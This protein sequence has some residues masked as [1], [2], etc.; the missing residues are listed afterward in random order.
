MKLTSGCKR[1]DDEVGGLREGM[2][3]TVFGP[4][5]AGK[6]TIAIQYAL[7]ALASGYKVF[8][9]NTEDELFIDRLYEMSIRRGLN[10]NLERLHVVRATSFEEQHRILTR[11]LKT[12]GGGYGLI[13]VDSL[14]G[15]FRLEVGEST[16][17]RTLR[18]LNMQLATIYHQA[19]LKDLAAIVTSQV[20]TGESD[21]GYVASAQQAL[22]FW[23][24]LMLRLD[25]GAT[26]GSRII[27]VIKPE[28]KVKPWR[29]TLL[30]VRMSSEGLIC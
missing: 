9:V 2:L 6:T 26:L 11:M 21:V 16:L 30:K 29:K 25:R 10:V 27:E 4:A 8:Y 18:M 7:S 17:E 13:V 5:G 24:T 19:V 15:L 20:R 22:K 1:L 28:H 3:T 12:L 23:S 14:T